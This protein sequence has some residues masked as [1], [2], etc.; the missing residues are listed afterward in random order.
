MQAT[1]T[2]FEPSSNPQM[3]QNKQICLAENFISVA[4]TKHNYSTKSAAAADLSYDDVKCII[5]YIC[6]N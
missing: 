6:T 5:D 2:C 1:A 3:S 4:V